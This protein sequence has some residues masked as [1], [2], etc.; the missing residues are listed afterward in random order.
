MVTMWYLN[1][2]VLKKNQRVLLFLYLLM[3]N[4]EEFHK[5]IDF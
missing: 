3:K 2:A 4:S 1:M 5:S